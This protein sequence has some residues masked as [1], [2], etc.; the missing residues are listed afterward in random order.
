M[1]LDNDINSFAMLEFQ[2][3]ELPIKFT[4]SEKIIPS[5]FAC[6]KYLQT[7][8]VRYSEPKYKPTEIQDEANS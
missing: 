2:S 8:R 5:C 6:L 7:Q 1:L 4:T 3:S